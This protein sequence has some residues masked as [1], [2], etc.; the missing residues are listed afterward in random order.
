[1]RSAAAAPF[2]IVGNANDHLGS[3]I[4]VADVDGDGYGDFIML[5][6]AAA[7]TSSMAGPV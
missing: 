2:K 3:S 4:V 7:N 1:M 5:R 6:A